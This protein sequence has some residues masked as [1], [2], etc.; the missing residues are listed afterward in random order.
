MK[1]VFAVMAVAGL[2][3]TAAA[4]VQINE[5]LGSTSGSDAEFIEL[6]NTGATAVD[7]TNW[8]IELWDSD[9][10]ASF[11]QADGSAPYF[12]TGSIAAGGYFTLGT[13]LA[14]ATY[15]FTAD[16][17]LGAN[18]IENSSYT[19]VLVDNLGNTIETFFMTD[20]GAGDA[21]NI[22]G[23]LITPDTTFGPDGTFLPAGAYRVDDGASWS[24]L[25]FGQ[26][27]PSATPGAA[28][29]PAPASLALLGLGGLAAGRRRRA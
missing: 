12:M 23:T 11:G 2:A 7:L 1:T 9:A 21:A 15:G 28:N 27:S 24:I 14:E 3:A 6:H 26:P 10:G 4:D 22:A 13:A 16:N 18:S 17:P 19:M 5:I 25:E 20:G 29:I 8:S